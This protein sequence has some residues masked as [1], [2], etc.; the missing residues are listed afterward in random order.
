MKRGALRV[1]PDPSRGQF[2]R[3]SCCRYPPRRQ[4][5]PKA[6][7]K[8]SGGRYKISNSCSESKSPETSKSAASTASS[9]VGVHCFG[10]S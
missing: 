2:R 8:S 9:R 1:G 4:R 7:F 5:K 10:F 6:K 3:R